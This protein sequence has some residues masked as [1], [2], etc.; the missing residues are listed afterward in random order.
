MVPLDL[1]PS[2]EQPNQEAQRIDFYLLFEQYS[3]MAGI[4]AEDASGRVRY[5]T[6]P[7]QE[8]IPSMPISQ[9]EAREMLEREHK[10]HQDKYHPKNP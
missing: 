4:R 1:I 6:S 3:G 8:D 5:F 2:S 7:K 10:R 9:Q